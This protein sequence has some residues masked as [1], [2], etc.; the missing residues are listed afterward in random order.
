MDST[1]GSTKMATLRP[2]DLPK[3]DLTVFGADPS[4]GLLTE[5]TTGWLDFYA[6]GGTVRAGTTIRN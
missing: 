2:Y 5:Q 1:G 3:Y 4:S 6:E